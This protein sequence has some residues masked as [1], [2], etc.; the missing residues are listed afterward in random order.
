[1][2]DEFLVQVKDGVVTLTGRVNWT[3]ERDA[4]E[5]TVENL[6]GV[7]QIINHI[8]VHGRLSAADVKEQIK[9]AF[10][11][12]ASLDAAQIQVE[13]QDGEV[14]LTGTVHAMIEYREAETVAW[15]GPG[16]TEVTNHFKVVWE[17]MRQLIG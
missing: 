11:R 15:A 3:H 8:N 2:K 14:M 13:T 5:H 6:I 4:A 17:F 9:K 7:R 1:V 10:E 16:V 12:T